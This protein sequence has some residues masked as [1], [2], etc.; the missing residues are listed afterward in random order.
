LKT[1]ALVDTKQQQGFKKRM[2]W[3]LIYLFLLACGLS[4]LLTVLGS[5][6]GHAFGRTGLF[7]G[8]VVGGIGGIALAGLIAR[9]LR[10]INHRS[11]VPTAIGGT[12]GYVLAAVIAVNNLDTPVV[13]MLSVT[14]V[15]LGAV[16]G[17]IARRNEV[18]SPKNTK[19]QGEV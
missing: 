7:V 16:V 1:F 9:R 4:G 11:Y 8:A 2:P 13:P 6:V 14:L 5:I 3:R 12:I 15:G 10:L 19:Q 17:G 18:E